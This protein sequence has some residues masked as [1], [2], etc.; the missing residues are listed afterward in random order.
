MEIQP[1]RKTPVVKVASVV[2]GGG[3][4]IVIQSM[5][6]TRTADVQATVHQIIELIEAGSEMV[7]VTVNND[8][9]ARAVPEIIRTIRDQGYLTPIIGDFHF[10]PAF[11]TSTASIPAISA[12][13]ISTTRI[14][15]VL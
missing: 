1:R 11:W 14:L 13:G 2:I 3:H 5:T 7:R 4:P 10:A 12:R 15:P 8:E 9:A 6:N